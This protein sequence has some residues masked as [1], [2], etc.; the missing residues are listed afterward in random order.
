MHVAK[1][2]QQEQQQHQL[3]QQQQQQQQNFL[4][5]PPLIFI[6]VP[7]TLPAGEALHLLL[8]SSALRKENLL[9]LEGWALWSVRHAPPLRLPRPRLTPAPTHGV[10]LPASLTETLRWNVCVASEPGE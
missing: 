1:Q 5:W 4:Y 6:A 3:Q 2:Q 7:P 9:W 10:R 8:A